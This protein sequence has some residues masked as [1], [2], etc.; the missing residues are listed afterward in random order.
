MQPFLKKGYSIAE[1]LIIFKCAFYFA[2]SKGSIFVKNSSADIQNT[3]HQI[4]LEISRL[5]NEKECGVERFVEV[6][7]PDC[8]YVKN[9]CQTANLLSMNLKFSKTAV[10]FWNIFLSTVKFRQR[11]TSSKIISL[12]QLETFL[13]WFSAAKSKVIQ[14][15]IRLSVKIYL[16]VTVDKR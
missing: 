7:L 16:L 8:I 2:L 13:C 6:Q 3:V 15:F 5:K 4:Q 11:L 14:K 10:M 12:C 9:N 1:L